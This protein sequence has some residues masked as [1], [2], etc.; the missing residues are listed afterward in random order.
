[1]IIGMEFCSGKTKNIMAEKLEFNLVLGNY[2]PEEAAT[3]LLSLI[4]S[5]INYHELDAFRQRERGEGDPRRSQRRIAE[6][7]ESRT[8]VR[9]LLERSEKEG[10]RISVKGVIEVAAD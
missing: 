10:L 6:L 5:K 1:M 7:T 2:T 3:V 9:G 4:N 8:K